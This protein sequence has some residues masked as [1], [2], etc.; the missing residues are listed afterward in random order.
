VNPNPPIPGHELLHEGH[1]VRRMARDGMYVP[2][3]Q[4]DAF[5][6]GCRCGAKPPG[7]P[8]LSTKAVKAWHR[9]HKAELRGLAPVEPDWRALLRQG[10]ALHEVST[11]EHQVDY[12]PPTGDHECSS[13]GEIAEGETLCPTLLWRQAVEQALAT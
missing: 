6:G 8:N 9:A 2:L 13:C 1:A 11:S 12:W 3:A 10:L 5:S 7:W 4:P